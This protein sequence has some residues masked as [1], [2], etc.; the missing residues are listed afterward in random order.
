MTETTTEFQERV[1]RG[2]ALLDEAKP[3]WVDYIDLTHFDIT[4]PCMCALGQVYEWYAAGCH[5]LGLTASISEV[6]D[7]EMAYRVQPHAHDFGFFENAHDDE[8]TTC[9][10]RLARW[11]ELDRAW[12]EL[13]EKRKA[14]A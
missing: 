12:Y 14:T 9:D 5:I 13:I 8:E 4:D 2:A 10:A 3:D 1:A 11:Q 6:T 7:G